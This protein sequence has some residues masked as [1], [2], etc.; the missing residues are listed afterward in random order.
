[1]NY[2]EETSIF[3]STTTTLVRDCE[4]TATTEKTSSKKRKIEELNF[5]NYVKLSFQRITNIWI[6][7]YTLTII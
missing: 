3:T 1:M 7:R 6:R 4:E 5:N 2:D